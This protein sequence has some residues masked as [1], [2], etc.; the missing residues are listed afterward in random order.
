MNYIYFTFI[1][2]MSQNALTTKKIITKYTGLDKAKV[3]KK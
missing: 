3:D 2:Y 1:K